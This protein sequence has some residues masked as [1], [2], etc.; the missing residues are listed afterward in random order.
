[1]S[2]DASTPFVDADEPT[3]GP[4]AAECDH[5]LARVHEFLDHEVD[6]ATGD[7]IRAH[8]TEC[9]PCLDRFDVEQAVK[10]LV[11]RCCGGDKAPDRLRVSIM[12]SITVTRRSL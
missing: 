7:E 2:T 11:K 1:M 8:L 10:S 3:S 9:E 5:V 12:S 4:T 6:T